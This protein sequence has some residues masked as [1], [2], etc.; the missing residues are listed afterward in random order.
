M[1]YPFMLA[2]V[3]TYGLFLLSAALFPADIRWYSSVKKPAWAPSGQL[4]VSARGFM[5]ACMAASVALVYVKTGGFQNVGIAWIFVVILHYLAGQAYGFFLFKA[6]SF[7]LAL[8]DSMIAALTGWWMLILTAPLSKES[9]WLL[10]PYLVW[11]C[12]TTLCT[13]IIRM[14]NTE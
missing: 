14:M 4:I 11:G 8:A 13:W 3:V 2:A 9:A 7:G 10:L 5:H 6:K 1:F 12:L